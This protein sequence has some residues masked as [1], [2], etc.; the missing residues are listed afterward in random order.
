M[1]D[2]LETLI[3][4]F[5]HVLYFKFATAAVITF[6]PSY[7]SSPSA[8]SQ[9]FFLCHDLL[10]AS[11]SLTIFT[12]SMRTQKGGET[13]STEM[14][15]CSFRQVSFVREASYTHKLFKILNNEH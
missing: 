2:P 3:N 5:S 6:L 7:N 8:G 1:V 4:I 13:T 14:A 12:V 10:R 15:R 11:V 9:P